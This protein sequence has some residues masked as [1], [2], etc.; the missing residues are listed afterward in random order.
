MPV[1]IWITFSDCLLLSN[2]SYF[3]SYKAHKFVRNFKSYPRQ[4]H[5]EFHNYLTI[6]KENDDIFQ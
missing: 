5:F 6:F 1:E 3:I 2:H 4:S